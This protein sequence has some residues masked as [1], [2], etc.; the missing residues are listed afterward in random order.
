MRKYLV[1]I[2]CLFFIAAKS[3]A[4]YV[5]IPDSNFRN[6]LKYQ[7]PTCFDTLNRLDTTS[8]IIN[9]L[10]LNLTYSKVKN[11]Y[12]I[13]YLKSLIQFDCLHNEIDT[14]WQFP[15]SIKYLTFI[16]NKCTNN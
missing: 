10:Y 16:D 5:S 12:G 13:Q 1:L 8:N 9:F 15:S 3:D 4:Q 6:E 11:I 7:C 2:C 14:V